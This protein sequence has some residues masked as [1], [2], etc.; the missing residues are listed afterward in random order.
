[1]FSPETKTHSISMITTSCRADV[2]THPLD[3][4]GVSV[5]FDGDNQKGDS[6]HELDAADG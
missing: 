1:M 4:G 3:V 2:T 6:V 5:V